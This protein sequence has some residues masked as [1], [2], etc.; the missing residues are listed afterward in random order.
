M[1]DSKQIPPLHVYAVEGFGSKSHW[2][3]MREIPHIGDTII[4]EN[5]EVARV[6]KVTERGQIVDEK[7]KKLSAGWVRLEDVQDPNNAPG[8]DIYQFMEEF[9]RSKS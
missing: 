8:S 9:R 2:L 1:A 3:K 7:G 5:G 6:L 4:I